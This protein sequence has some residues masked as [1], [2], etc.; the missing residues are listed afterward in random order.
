VFD[1]VDSQLIFAATGKGILRSQD[2]GMH[3]TVLSTDSG[4]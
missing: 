2:G 3:F 1:P 4:L